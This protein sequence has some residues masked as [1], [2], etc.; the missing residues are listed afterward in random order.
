MM[1]FLDWVQ[2]HCFHFHVTIFL[3]KEPMT[4]ATILKFDIILMNTRTE[5]VVS[6]NNL[7][8]KTANIYRFI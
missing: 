2:G 4:I 8:K 1:L 6:V 7:L 3:K 5:T